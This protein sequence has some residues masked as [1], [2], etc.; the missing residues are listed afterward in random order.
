MEGVSQ[1]ISM[2]GTIHQFGHVVFEV[3]ETATVELNA[4]LD[5][6]HNL[7][8]G[9]Y[10]ETYLKMHSNARLILDGYF[11]VFYGASIEIFKGAVLKLGGGYINTGCVIACANHI[12]IGEGAAIARGVFIY[13]SDHH[14][15]LDE[16]DKQINAS[17]P[18]IIGRHV[19]IGAGAI[20]LKGVSI[21]DGAVIAAGAVVTRD[22]P[23]RCLAAGNP[24]KVIKKDVKWR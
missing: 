2:G 6:G 13:D 7:C 4:N 1:L 8:K 18:V 9:S 17:A 14:E 21:G 16:Y 23:A 5:L 22:V 15:I 20:I 24:A 12:T 3:D 19:W 10:A 11:K